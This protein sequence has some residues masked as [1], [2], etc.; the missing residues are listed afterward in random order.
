MKANEL[1]IG[2]WVYNSHHKKPIQMTPYD[3]FTHSH[4]DGVPSFA[5]ILHPKPRLGRDLEPISLSEEILKANGWEK[6]GGHYV[7]GIS[8]CYYKNGFVIS[9]GEKLYIYC[10]MVS[11][12]VNYVHQLQHALRL[13]GLN[14]LADSLMT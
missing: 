6:C 3:F 4:T 10:G 14:E 8:P 5:N 7:N 2:D 11:L 13:C 1:M 9:C 12:P